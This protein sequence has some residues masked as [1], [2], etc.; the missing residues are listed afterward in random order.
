MARRELANRLAY[1]IDRIVRSKTSEWGFIPAGESALKAS[2]PSAVPNLHCNRLQ[3]PI[4]YVLRTSKSSF[5]RLGSDAM[6]TS[7]GFE[8]CMSVEA[9]QALWPGQML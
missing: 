9:L 7:R 8:G 4:R 5:P 1:T 3:I 2:S 6:L